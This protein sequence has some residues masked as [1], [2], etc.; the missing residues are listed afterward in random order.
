[1]GHLAIWGA[2]GTGKTYTLTGHYLQKPEARKLVVSF[3]NETADNIR[4]TLTDLTGIEVQKDTVN[5]IHGACYRLLGSKGY[6][7]VMQP[8]DYTKFQQETG[9]A[10]TPPVRDGLTPSKSKGLVDCYGWL[11]NTK[12]PVK[13]MV[14]FPGWDKIKLS[15]KRSEE[16]LKAYDQWKREHGKLDFTDMLTEVLKQRL[17]PDC[18]ILMVDEFQDLTAL[19]YDIFK[20]WAGKIKNVVIAGDPLQSIY[21][22]WGGSPDYFQHFQAEHVI[23]E[24]SHRL[25]RQIWEYAVKVAG[26]DKMEAPKI[27]AGEHKGTITHQNHTKYLK[28]TGTWQGTTDNTVFHLVRSN[29]QAP[30]IAHEMARNGILWDGI[31]GWTEQETA[32]LNVLIRAKQSDNRLIISK[33]EMLALLEQFPLNV[34]A[35]GGT[36]KSIRAD[37]KKEQR[38]DYGPL[39]GGESLYK[40]LES[41]DPVSHMSH[42]G[43]LKRAKFQNALKRYSKP[44]KWQDVQATTLTTIHGSK[45]LE[46]D[47]VFLHTGITKNIKKGMRRDRAEE[48]RVF[49]VGI[50]RAKKDLVIVKD[51][52]DNFPLPGVR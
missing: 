17:I 1:M 13:D 20:M 47:K 23:L 32:V 6:A 24:R 43:E 16:A 52:G 27:E 34:F 7:D 41:P 45:G 8:A 15:R 3:R 18:D 30:A 35:H 39:F 21:S 29:Y 12:R 22:F 33:Y 10:L 49:Y 38:E 9:Y 2:P 48:A 25:P 36:K 44:V 31:S 19:Q 42:K 4:A 37:I 5:T 28:D 26:R 11:H 51:K 14:K 50:T 40:I 46:A